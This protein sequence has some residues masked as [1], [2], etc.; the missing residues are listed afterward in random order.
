MGIYVPFCTNTTGFRAL[1][2]QKN[3]EKNIINHN[4]C[5]NS[6]C[7]HNNDGRGTVHRRHILLRAISLGGLG[8]MGK[9]T[10]HTQIWVVKL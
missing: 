8:E 1:K 4:Q 9:K 3:L 7:V 6:I 10:S 5:C 2:L